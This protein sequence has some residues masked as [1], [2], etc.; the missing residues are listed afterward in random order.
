MHPG[1]SVLNNLTKPRSVLKVCG[2][3]TKLKNFKFPTVQKTF[4][5]FLHF[6]LQS[7][8]SK[9][10]WWRGL[11]VL[12]NTFHLVHVNVGLILVVRTRYLGSKNLK[13][14]IHGVNQLPTLY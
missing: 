2:E 10:C 12:I 7:I 8:L 14:A 13:E 6:T 9:I 3:Y 4:D 5:S 1:A 11:K